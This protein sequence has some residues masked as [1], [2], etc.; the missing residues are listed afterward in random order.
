MS[1]MLIFFAFL[2]RLILIQKRFLMK[3]FQIVFMVLGLGIAQVGM[4]QGNDAGKATRLQNTRYWEKEI[5]MYKKA[6]ESG[7][8]PNVM[9][10]LADCYRMTGDLEKAE[11][12]YRNAIVNGNQ[13]TSC[14]LNYA[15]VLQSNGKYQEAKDQ[16]VLYEEITGEYA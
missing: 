8:Q 14:R 4:A 9:E 1:E 16:F 15:K 11:V 13:N 10:K 7:Q 5:P 2:P 12:W 6:L 3:Y